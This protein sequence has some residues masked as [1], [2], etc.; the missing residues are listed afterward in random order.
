MNGINGWTRN[1]TDDCKDH[2]ALIPIDAILG[3]GCKCRGTI[4]VPTETITMKTISTINPH[5]EIL[6]TPKISEIIDLYNVIFII[7]ET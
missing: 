7:K 3:L 1:R 6:L 2:A 4:R 5:R